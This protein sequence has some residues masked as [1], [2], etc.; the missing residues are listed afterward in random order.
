MKKLF[1]LS[2]VALLAACGAPKSPESTEAPRTVELK[3][4]VLADVARLSKAARH[5]GELSSALMIQQAMIDPKLTL[6]QVHGLSAG[7]VEFLV[8]E[9][10]QVSGLSLD[11]DDV[12]QL[13]QE[14]LSRAVFVLSSEF[15]WT[16]DRCA[17]LTVGQVLLYLEMMGRGERP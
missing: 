10:N 5:D 11:A 1:I 17:D 6:D 8:G 3:P 14:P 16:P 15:G 4:L 13:I 7:L 9:I 2:L 12:T